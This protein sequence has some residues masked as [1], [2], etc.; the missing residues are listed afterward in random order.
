MYIDGFF[1]LGALA[2]FLFAIGVMFA[3]RANSWDQYSQQDGLADFAIDALTAASTGY[4]K[5][6]KFLVIV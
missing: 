5:G 2:T 4:G 6:P 1:S 3:G